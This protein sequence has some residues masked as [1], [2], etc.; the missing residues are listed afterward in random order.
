[1]NNFDDIYDKVTPLLTAHGKVFDVA[2]SGGVDSV[3]LLHLL[4]R[5][6]AEH[7]D[8][9]L[10]AVHVNHGLSSNAAHW[11]Q[12]CEILC[13]KWDV[14]LKTA[15]VTVEDKNRVSL[16]AAARDARYTAF[17]EHV[18]S[19]SIL[20]LGQHQDDQ[21]ET[22]LLRLKR[23]SGL[24]GLSSMRLTG[25]TKMGVQWLRPLLSISRQ[26]IEAY[27]D[28]YQL[29]HIEDESNHD[30]RFDRNFIRNDILPVMNERFVGFNGCVARSIEILQQQS[31]LLLHYTEQ[32]YQACQ[33]Q[34]R[35]D[36]VLFL[37]MSLLRQQNIIRYWL[38]QHQ[39]KMP[40]KAWLTQLVSQL[41]QITSDNEMVVSIEQFQ[42]RV[43]RSEV[44]LV[45]KPHPVPKPMEL[46]A[47]NKK[48]VLSD[49]R[50]LVLKAGKGLRLPNERVKITVAFDQGTLKFKPWHKPGSNKVKHWLKDAKI[51]SWQR[52]YVPLIF[53]DDELVQVVGVGVSA[54]YVT[55]DGMFWIVEE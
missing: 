21:V 16:E 13:L 39:V 37:S 54:D 28:A 48:W 42:V 27:A 41:N 29:K 30:T 7:P 46:D 24:D 55:D 19:N 14:S 9:R 47:T 31:E 23:G 45:A 44:Y 15:T 50:K 22:F 26:Q 12:Y 18:A 3:V 4:V 43:Y 38:T 11:Q 52:P 49:G 6:R 8:T 1:M 10:N 5:F 17:S 36:L 53:F 34:G 40:S 35:I 2:L 33:N 51:P 25:V 32:D 20:L